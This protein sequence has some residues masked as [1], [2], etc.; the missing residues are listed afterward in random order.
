MRIEWIARTGRQY[1]IESRDDE[2]A[3]AEILTAA[4]AKNASRA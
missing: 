3:S 4:G 2:I 1:C